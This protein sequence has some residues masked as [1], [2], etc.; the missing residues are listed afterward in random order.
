MLKLDY[1]D[2]SCVRSTCHF[3]F[4]FHG[5]AH[6]LVKLAYVCAPNLTRA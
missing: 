4:S 3:A 2:A 5:A 1:M 6:Y